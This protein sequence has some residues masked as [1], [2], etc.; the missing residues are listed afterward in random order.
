MEGETGLA[1]D[2]WEE[3]HK[4]KKKLEW[5][6][7]E[8]RVFLR[9]KGSL[10][11]HVW[12]ELLIYTLLYFAISLLYRFAF[13]EDQQKYFKHLIEYCK[14]LYAGLPLMFILGF[15]VSMVVTRWWALYNSLPWPDEV[16]LYLRE[17]ISG[18]DEERR[19]V[20]R[21]IMRYCILS[22]I[23]ALRRHLM[24]LR[25][26]YQTMASLI[27]TGIVTVE[28]ME[29][30]DEDDLPETYTS[31][32]WVP[33]QWCTEIIADAKA[34]DLV[35]ADWVPL[36]QIVTFKQKL[37]S[38]K[39]YGNIPVPL[40]YNQVVTLAVYIY[41][42]CTLIADQ[43]VVGEPLDLWYPFFRHHEVLIL[44][45]MAQYCQSSLQPSG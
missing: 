34:K 39:T 6:A 7:W 45:G 29:R 33:L 9:W 10:W 4:K 12:D 44:L 11:K 8:K 2:K 32:W 20:R 42:G 26:R 43:W 17:T 37:Q 14:T 27:K 41:F 25:R 19:I 23:L 24:K 16:A 30:I 13:T 36:G 1:I 5:P 21:T 28:E 35:S 3:N 22:Y 40:V 15:Y 31:N 38:V 18:E